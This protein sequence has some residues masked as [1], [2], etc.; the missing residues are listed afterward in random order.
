M[1]WVP[2]LGTL[3]RYPVPSRHCNTV[4]EIP[5]T[6]VRI[7]GNS[8]SIC[9]NIV[10]IH[11]KSVRIHGN[12][13][14]IHGKFDGIRATTAWVNIKCITNSRQIYFNYLIRQ[15]FEKI[16]NFRNT[17]HNQLS[18]SVFMHSLVA[19]LYVSLS[20]RPRE[21][22]SY[23]PYTYL[24]SCNLICSSLSQVSDWSGLCP[25]GRPA[26]RNRAHQI[27]G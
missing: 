19:K 23:I 7:C 22:I 2:P 21:S 27:H 6:F 3:I 25:F 1:F 15:S 26:V 8:V 13:V 10:R 9:S 4:H 5:R 16:P 20:I 17:M 18:G 11:G 24:F 12:S 14:S